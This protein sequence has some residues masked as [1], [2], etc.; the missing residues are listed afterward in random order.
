MGVWHSTVKAL[1]FSGTLLGVGPLIRNSNI[2][3]SSQ[4]VSCRVVSRFEQIDPI[5][6]PRWG[7]F[8]ERHPNASVF[9][10]PA[11]LRSLHRTYG[12][13][14]TVFTT[15]G[16]EEPLRDGLVFCR[17]KGWFGRPRLVSL[18]FSDHVELLVADRENMRDILTFVANGAAQGRW[19]SVEIR[20][21]QP[22]N[23]AATAADFVDGQSFL[24]HTLDLQPSLA[25]LY[26]GLNK[27]STRRKILKAQRTGLKYDEGGSERHLEQFFRM[28]VMTRMR[29]ALPPPPLT[30]FRNLVKYMGEQLKIRIA[31]T[32]TGELAGAIL[33]LQYKNSMV[34]KYGASDAAFHN[35]GTMPFLLWHAIEDAKSGGATQFDF[36]RSEV[37]N[38]GLVRFK[39]HFGAERNSFTHKIFPAT[40]WRPDAHNWQL[41]MAKRVFAHLPQSALVLAGRLIYPY[42]G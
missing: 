38:P 9:H 37:D 33:T 24:L 31:T 17:V 5:S 30:W 6:D 29:K 32:Q 2:H 3:P 10:T 42:I 40:A 4:S 12:Y 35:L 34:F 36:G 16:P 26:Q 15:S 21:S 19:S 25:N 27:D 7:E 14:P 20:P 13:E 23:G 22:V 39:E 8:L 1:N 11:W 41:T 28:C 18:P